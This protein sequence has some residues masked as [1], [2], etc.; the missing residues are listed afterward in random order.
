MYAHTIYYMLYYKHIYITQTYIAR[1]LAKLFSSI[2]VLNAY[3]LYIYL[4]ER[5]K[6]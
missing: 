2:C 4:N 5:I 1:K 3:I 6:G